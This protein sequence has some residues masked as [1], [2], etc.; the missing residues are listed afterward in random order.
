MGV[1]LNGVELNWLVHPIVLKELKL[2]KVRF[3]I[4]VQS[5]HQIAKL[6]RLSNIV[7][8]FAEVFLDDLVLP[9]QVLIEELRDPHVVGHVV[10]LLTRV[11]GFV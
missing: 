10:L 6:V 2:L 5:D 4:L 9:L 3:S 8:P 1:L 7:D 11:V